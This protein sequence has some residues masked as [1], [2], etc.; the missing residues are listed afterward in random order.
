MT[1]ISDM[2]DDTSPA[3]SE[4]T[5]ARGR[6]GI[7]S[8]YST[9]GGGVTLER[10]VSATYLALL[11][12][13]EGAAELGDG[14][15]VVSVAFQQAPAFPVDD[16]VIE[17]SRPDELEPSLILA[18]G[19]RRAPKIVPSDEDTQKLI[20]SFVKAVTATPVDGREYRLAL[21]VS[22][23]QEHAS[24]L[25]ELAVIADNQRNAA[26]FFELIQTP[27]KF[28]NAI[29][30]RLKSLKTLVTAALKD[31][32]TGDPDDALAQLHTWELLSRLSV[33][34]PRLEQPDVSDW[35]T[36]ANRLVP[37][38]RG[39]DLA[40]ARQL[41]DRLE[42]LAGQYGPSAATIDMRLLRRDVHTLLAPG[43]SRNP[44][45]WALLKH[46]EAQAAAD[47]RNRIERIGGDKTLSLDRTAEGAEIITAAKD[48]TAVVV[49]GDSGTGKSALVIETVRSE[50]HA[51]PTE[52]QAICLNLRHLPT[53][54]LELVSKLGCP[55]EA[56]L[57]E[58]SAPSRFL[59]VDGADAA[60]ETATEMFTYLIT[61]ARNSG[62]GVVAVTA[63]DSQQVI[64]DL[65]RDHLPG[66]V[67]T[68]T[69]PALND[70]QLTDIASRFPELEQLIHTP[71]S[72]QLLRR[73]VVVD[74]LV[75]SNVTGL[76]MSDLDAMQQIWTRLVRRHEKRDRGLPDARQ[77]VLL[78]L[79]ARELSGNAPMGLV[80]SLDPA[81][82]AGLRQDGLL[83]PAS[84]NPWE[85]IPAFAHEEIRRYAVARVLLAN[86]DPATGL[87]TA[88]APR[89]AM[90][91]SRLACQALLELPDGPVSPLPG[92]LSR[93][94]G[95]FDRLVEA[96]HGAR[97]GD[98][99]GEAL[100][101]LGDPGPL[102][103]D[104]WPS[105]RGEEASGL[106]RLLRLMDQR[107]RD[108]HK[109]VDPTTAEPIVALLLEE[110][111]P[112]EVHTTI[113]AFLRD[114][115]RAL[116]VRNSPEGQ[117]LRVR[118]RELLVAAC[119]QGEERLVRQQ[120]E[121]DAAR[122]TRTPEQV[123]EERKFEERL[124]IF[125]PIGRRRRAIRNRP[126]VPRELTDGTL[127]ELLA[128]LSAD[129]G[130]TG[131][132]LLRRVARDAPWDLAPAVEELLTGQALA[133][134][135]DG[136]LADLTEAYYLDEE[137]DGTGLHED[138]IRRHRGRGPI[139]PLAAYYRGPFLALFQTDLR[140][141]LVVLNRMLNHAALVR[142]RSL[143]GL[144]D[145]RRQV[146]EDAVHYYK[147]E[148][149][150][151]GQPRVYVGDGHVWLWYRGTGVGPY[152]CMSALQAL[153]RVCDQLL[154]VGVPLD[155]LVTFLLDG[156]ENLAMLGLVV[157]LLIRHL[158][159]AGTLLDPFLAEPIIWELEFN[160]QASE[161]SGLAANSQGLVAP[162]R[163]RWSLREAASYLTVHADAER[164]SQLK[165][166]GEQLV[167]TAEQLSA[168]EGA[169]DRQA[170]ETNP[171]VTYVTRVRNWAC[172]LDQDRYEAYNQDGSIYVQSVPPEDVQAALRPGAE[173]LR[174]GQ[175]AMRLQWRYVLQVRT[176]PEAA[177][178]ATGDELAD[179][180][181]IAKDLLGNPPDRSPVGSWDAAVAVSAA[182]IEAHVR[183]GVVVSSD[184][185]EF[186]AATV[187][188][189][190]EGA[191]A[192]HPF[193][194]EDSYYEQG[195]DRIAARALPLL[196]YAEIWGDGGVAR[197]TRIAE[198]G[199]R[200]AQATPYGRSRAVRR[201]RVIINWP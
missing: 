171:A 85:V 192:P 147:I 167:A 29:V 134:Y 169:G 191:V 8:P 126:A 23:Y 16:L 133:S 57:G 189:V 22:G 17:A 35:S 53:S 93:L 173:D 178:P 105:L 128:L 43:P 50:A 2:Q 13:G 6:K 99:P 12:T 174:R 115:L 42:T 31:L 125:A 70:D 124:A 130:D 175:E 109:L 58:L 139:S 95:A 150:I 90:S 166:I 194:S 4:P 37:V 69:V 64:T 65:L 165:A 144:G 68:Y 197:E 118:L 40:G 113:A 168:A 61:S 156:C 185:L 184:D 44:Q 46:L 151:T 36:T 101:T 24:Q 81:A 71:R 5:E 55:L 154:T 135:G 122:A 177:T 111:R 140:R 54:S 182:A 155:S 76:P 195:A 199:R 136:L 117:P 112:W 62:V 94:Q 14:R 67:V 25:A 77:Q 181:A 120:Q 157:G 100:L 83:R 74:L 92:R 110:P 73:L 146:P 127:L 137:E 89:W 158:D 3:D 103:A 138:G 176:N 193:E 39:N 190:V 27:G 26:A 121:A 179:D 141:G 131:A 106:Q 107:H 38:A 52:F 7:A 104:A 164:A 30:V 91:A 149:C 187:L 200:L 47:V 196:L 86:G 132:E 88:G 60:T 78:S 180:L 51:N 98:V 170:T 28:K 96:G 79:A 80:G 183:H 20:T 97:W 198:A 49:Q 75:R 114:W 84:D 160:R 145:A 33:L 142:A 119:A 172:A 10:R 15:A 56:L 143:A 34:M 82:V 116:V 148:L 161:P 63:S 108:V 18:I 32:G 9:G 87:L 152:P 59:V 129:L 159:R 162:E 72:R 163:R 123:E 21:V 153:E 11:L 1:G 48:A 188:A 41:L 19:I 102:L 186:A 201:A 45:G 66:N